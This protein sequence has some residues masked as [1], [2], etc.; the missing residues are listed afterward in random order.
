MASSLRCERRPALG[1]PPTPRHSYVLLAAPP[2]APTPGLSC[3]ELWLLRR[4]SRGAALPWL[5]SMGLVRPAAAAPEC[6]AFTTS[7][8]DRFRVSRLDD[9][10]L[11]PWDRAAASLPPPPTTTVVAPSRWC[12]A[13]APR[14]RSTRDREA[15]GGACS[16]SVLRRLARPD[17]GRVRAA[18]T[19][20]LMATPAMGGDELWP[21]S[22]TL[23]GAREVVN[24]DTTG[25]GRLGLLSGPPTPLP[26]SLPASVST[27][28]PGVVAP[29]PEAAAPGDGPSW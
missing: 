24:D 21:R 16:E 18:F 9:F 19:D 22:A 28:F 6:G 14:L 5:A 2:P 15:G 1:G 29:P 27:R 4:P 26:A 25:D 7:R 23:H 10:G 11:G 17:L 8:A 3:R 12:V 13:N 20:G